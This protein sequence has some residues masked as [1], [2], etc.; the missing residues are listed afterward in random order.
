MAEDEIEEEEKK[1]ERELEKLL[2]GN[3]RGFLN[4]ANIVYKTSDFTSAAILYFK[5][6]FSILDIII[7]RREGKIPK[8]HS[9]RFRILESKYPSLYLMIDKLYPIYRDTYTSTINKETCEKI[10]ENAERLAKEQKVLENN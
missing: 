9:E 5:A 2:K 10:K 7:L 8:D 6:L 1:T 4:S 3:I